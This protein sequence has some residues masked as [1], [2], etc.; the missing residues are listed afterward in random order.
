MKGILESR[1]YETVSLQNNSGQGIDVIG[2]KRRH[3]RTL[4]LVVEVKATSGSRPPGLAGSRSKVPGP[5]QQ[6]L[7]SKVP[8]PPQQNLG[9]WAR[10][11]LRSIEQ[12]TGRFRNQPNPDR[13]VARQFLA[14]IDIDEKIGKI[15][16]A[17][18]VVDVRGVGQLGPPTAKISG[19]TH[20]TPEGVK[21]H[22]LKRG[23]GRFR[24]GR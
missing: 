2:V 23:R 16:A 4:L 1:G 22:P 13:E 14:L 19:F 3:G 12:G 24:P 11:R 8:G 7:G 17:A 15:P 10:T 6:N 18:I 5:P 20:V 9:E 21:A